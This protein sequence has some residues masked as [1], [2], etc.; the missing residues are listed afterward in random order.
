MPITEEKYL[1][2]KQEKVIY[3]IKELLPNA[4]EYVVKPLENGSFAVNFEGG[5]KFVISSN[6]G[7]T[8][9]NL[10]NKNVEKEIKTIK[11][12]T[13]NIKP[14]LKTFV[15]NMKGYDKAK[16]VDGKQFNKI[17][18]KSG[19][20]ASFVF[21][22]WNQIKQELKTAGIKVEN[23]MSVKDD[24]TA[25]EAKETFQAWLKKNTTSLR[26]EYKNYLDDMKGIKEKPMSF[27]E[28]AKESF[29]NQGAMNEDN[30]TE[31]STV[32]NIVGKD[33]L[34][35]FIEKGYKSKYIDDFTDEL[36]QYYMGKKSPINNREE[37]KEFYSVMSGRKANLDPFQWFHKRIK[38]L[39]GKNMKE[40][41]DSISDVLDTLPT[42]LQ[43]GYRDMNSSSKE[44]L[45]AILAHMNQK[46]ES[47]SESRSLLKD[48]PATAE[49]PDTENK[50]PLKKEE[51]KVEPEK[52]EEP[53]KE[54]PKATDEAEAVFTKK[55]YAPIAKILKTAKDKKEIVSGVAK[56]FKTQNEMFDEAKFVE[57]A[58]QE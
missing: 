17:A 19:L 23:T 27:E 9:V 45:N 52:K 24:Y 28:W 33:N 36:L 11:E 34:N 55:H 31:L 21:D 35:S 50:E 43:K 40:N 39:L 49:K 30:N 5:D 42:E 8:I 56:L 57:Y 58:G 51:P 26:A 48:A 20:G 15:A 22:H 2:S 38:T 14:M 7:I 32:T 1:N 41:T 53:T 10:K 18:S 44:V 29:E 3:A 4:P 37:V 25:N 47:I 6:G 46:K 12:G 13:M 54:E 16:D